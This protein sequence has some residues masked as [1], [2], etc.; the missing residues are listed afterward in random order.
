MCCRRSSGWRITSLARVSITATAAAGASR[1]RGC[2]G[3][4]SMRSAMPRKRWA[5]SGFQI[6]TPATMKALLLPRQPEARPALVVGARLPRRLNC[7]N[8]RLET[9][10]LV[11]RLI[12]ESGRAAGVLFH[13]GGETVEARAKGEVILC[14]GSIGTTQV[15]HRSGIG[16]PNGCRRSVDIAD[17]QASATSAGPSAAAR[18]TRF[19]RAHAERNLLQPDAAA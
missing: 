18:S 13:Q 8:L 11:D 1:R 19:R 15:L 5:S 3:R 6:S 16:P 12:I 7:S 17:V 4:S 9:N 10:V 14:A 2:R